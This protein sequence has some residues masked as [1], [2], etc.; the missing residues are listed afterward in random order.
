MGTAFKME[1]RFQ[2]V[3]KHILYINWMIGAGYYLARPMLSPLWVSLLQKEEL[4]LI[5]KCWSKRPQLKYSKNSNTGQRLYCEFNYS[6]ASL[7]IG[8]HSICYCFSSFLFF[9][10]LEVYIY[11]PCM[12]KKFVSRSEIWKDNQK[13]LKW[14]EHE[15]LDFN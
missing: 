12:K 13:N 5:K 9:Q 14:N 2:S 15:W 6:S 8:I 3:P 11:I 1:N 10:S 4:M 7:L